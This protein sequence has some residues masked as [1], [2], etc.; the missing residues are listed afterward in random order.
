MKFL[1]AIPLLFV[2]FFSSAQPFEGQ[3]TYQNSYKSKVPGVSNKDYADMY[4]K[5]YVYSIKEGDYKIVTSNGMINWQLYINKDNKIYNKIANA[6]AIVWI[7]GRQNFD[8][9]ISTEIK[10]N[11]T[12]VLGYA[13]DELTIIC[14]NSIEK[15]YFSSYLPVDISKFTQHLYGHWYDYLKVSATIPLKTITEN[16]QFVTTSTVTNVKEMKL[17]ESLFQLPR[18]AKIEKIKLDP[19]Y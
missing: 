10:K 11:A 19:K 2:Y 17:S 8:S 9:I 13:C 16:D 7:D 12:E 6:E 3:I 18:N 1:L 4:G 15:Y 14:K 5:S